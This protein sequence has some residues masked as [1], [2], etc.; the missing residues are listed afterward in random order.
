MLAPY[1]LNNG[2]DMKYRGGILVDDYRGVRR[3][4]HGGADA[5]YRSQFAV[6]PDHDLSIIVLCNFANATPGALVDQVADLLLKDALKPVEKDSGEAYEVAADKLSEYTGL[7]HQPQT[8]EVRDFVLKDGKLTFWGMPLNPRSADRFQLAEF[9]MFIVF[10]RDASG[11]IIGHSTEPNEQAHPYFEKV[12][13]PSHNAETLAAYV[14]RY[15]SDELATFYDVVLE[16]EKLVLRHLRHA[17]AP[18]KPT[19]H[20]AF[21]ADDYAEVVFGRNDDGDVQ[22]LTFYTSRVRGITLYRE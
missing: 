16:G 11:K 18:M 3:Y 21:K 10:K 22:T 2:K 17:D 1:A 14:G 4:Q 15:A 6:F 13:A 20:D 8:H 12:D 19:Y 5:G 7:Y 9:S